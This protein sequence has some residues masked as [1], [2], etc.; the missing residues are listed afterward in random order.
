MTFSNEMGKSY[1]KMKIGVLEDNRQSSS[2]RR[3]DQ[4]CFASSEGKWLVEDEGRR[5]EA[6]SVLQVQSEQPRINTCLPIYIS[7]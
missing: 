7:L 1:F 5:T 2:A 6:R 4:F 3:D